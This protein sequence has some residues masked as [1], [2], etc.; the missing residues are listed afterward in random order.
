MSPRDVIGQ[1]L[2]RTFRH[3]DPGETTWD[4]LADDL[5]KALDEQ[6]VAVVPKEKG[7]EGPKTLRLG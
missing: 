4:E 7:P 2:P 3:L 5:L 1:W 6:G